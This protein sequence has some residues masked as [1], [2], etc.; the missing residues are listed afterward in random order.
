MKT[1]SL[2]GPGPI[3]PIDWPEARAIFEEKFSSGEC[4]ILILHGS[5][6][7]LLIEIEERYYLGDR[8]ADLTVMTFGAG[9][10]AFIIVAA[11]KRHMLAYQLKSMFRQ[12]ADIHITDRELLRGDAIIIAPGPANIQMAVT[13]ANKLLFHTDNDLAMSE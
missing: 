5:A 12:Y 10:Q 3:R 8:N 4:W 9:W 11:R 6:V 7:G 13:L 1:T 2:Q